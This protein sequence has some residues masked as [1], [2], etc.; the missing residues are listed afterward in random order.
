MLRLVL[1]TNVIVSALIAPHGVPASILG[2]V[3]YHQA[4]LC[5]DARILSEYE[6]VINRPKFNFSSTYCQSLIKFIKKNGLSVVAKSSLIEMKDESDR[7]FL[8]VAQSCSATLITGNAKHFP[9]QQFICS[10]SAFWQKY[11]IDKGC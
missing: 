8:E 3:L 2:L 9:P 4:L 1:D 11:A 6:E 10:P 5:Y 7:M